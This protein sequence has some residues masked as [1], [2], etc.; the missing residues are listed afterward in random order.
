MQV[1]RFYSFEVVSA[2]SGVPRAE[3]LVQAEEN[4][5]RGTFDRGDLKEAAGAAVALWSR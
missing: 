5:G 1:F 3:N 2:L 4:S